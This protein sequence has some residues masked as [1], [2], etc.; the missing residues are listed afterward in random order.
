[1][2]QHV[3]NHPERYDVLAGILS[4]LIP[5]LGQ[6]YQGRVGKGLLFMLSLYTLFF[7]GMY[8]G[9]FRNVY[10]PRTQPGIGKGGKLGR[11]FDDLYERLHFVGQ[12]WLG[13]A[14]WPAIYQ[15]TNYDEF[16]QPPYP[17]KGW[18]RAP[19]E[20]ELNTLQREGDKRWDL[21]W[22]YTVIAGVL[23][24]LVIYDAV[25]GPAF[26]RS[27]ELDAENADSSEVVT[28]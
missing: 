15:Y 21:G 16:Q 25:A 9:S 11:P 4:Y 3:P 23:N 7:Y 14:V 24:I 27:D 8:L 5:G 6:M 28:T 26:R 1:M 18:M 10:L 19:M 20:D 13:I 12:F 22:V 17:L 2:H